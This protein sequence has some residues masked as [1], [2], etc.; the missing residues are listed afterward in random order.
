MTAQ[1][2][3]QIPTGHTGPM[4]QTHGF[5]DLILAAIQLRKSLGISTFRKHFGDS[6]SEEKVPFGLRFD[7]GE[8]CK[9]VH[10]EEQSKTVDDLIVVTSAV[11]SKNHTWQE[12]LDRGHDIGLEKDL[13]KLKLVRPQTRYHF[14]RPRF[15]MYPVTHDQNL[16]AWFMEN[17]L[18]YDQNRFKN[19]ITQKKG[20]MVNY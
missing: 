17:H 6:Q 7:A 9:L 14:A 8:I 5:R 12:H 13:R 16:N 3:F 11:F 15:V 1:A 18:V 20:F 10:L 2:L 19:S 4:A